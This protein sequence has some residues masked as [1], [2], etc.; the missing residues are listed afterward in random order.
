MF[1]SWQQK[2]LGKQLGEQWCP[3]LVEVRVRGFMATSECFLRPRTEL[4]KSGKMLGLGIGKP[5]S[6]AP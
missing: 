2:H 4:F 5:L 3:H 6:L 1:L